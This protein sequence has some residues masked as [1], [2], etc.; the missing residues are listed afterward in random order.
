M[1]LD[2]YVTVH[3]NTQNKITIRC[4]QCGN[5]RTID[6]D[7]Y[8]LIKEPFTVNITC[9]KCGHN[10]K[11][12]INF[13]KTYRK[14][15]NISGVCFTTNRSGLGITIDYMKVSKISVENIS[16]TG[17]GFMLKYPIHIEL[18][19]ILEIKIMLDNKK[20]TTI[21]KQIIVK[22]ISNNYIGAEFTTPVDER[23]KD[24]GFYL[25]P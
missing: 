24:L 17:I 8:E 18:G 16:R 6:A 10:F 23:H 7:F 11:I 14:E 12:F 9:N 2:S 21:T 15:T 1:D 4:E 5:F 13:R 25:M 3:V 22:Q 19:E 20:R